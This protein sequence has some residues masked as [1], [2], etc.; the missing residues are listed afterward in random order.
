MA[1]AAPAPRQKRPMPVQKAVV[2]LESVSKEYMLGTQ[3]VQAVRGVTL[4]VEPGVFMA[5]AGPSGSGKSTL[6]NMI[7]CIDASTSG[8][9]VVAG[10]DVS[11]V[12]PDDLA[13]LRART[14]GFIFQTFNL[15]PVLSAEENVEYPLLQFAE[16][17][18]KERRERVAHYLDLVQLSKHAKH[19]PGEMSGGQ[20]QR[21]AIA[22]ALATQPEL[23]LADEPTANLD[24]A[25]GENILLLM[26]QLNQQTKTTFIFSTHDRKVMSKADRLVWLED[27]Q[28]KLLGVRTPTKWMVIDKR[29]KP[30][31]AAPE[32]ASAEKEPA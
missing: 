25:T 28:I 17:S 27:G 19:R 7:G 6:L 24:H 29:R 11:G 18:K 15:L 20:R 12:S 30:K 5:I 3:K 31:A 4:S 23:V 14:I 13:E 1:H 8:R 16:L 10:H 9:I 21:V 26:K 22:R 2:Q 32:P